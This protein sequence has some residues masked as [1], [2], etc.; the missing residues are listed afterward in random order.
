MRVKLPS[1]DLIPN[2]CPPHFTNTYT[3]RVTTALKVHG[4]KKIRLNTFLERVL[5][6]FV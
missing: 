5:N 1:E 4:E 6:G 2:F 3:C